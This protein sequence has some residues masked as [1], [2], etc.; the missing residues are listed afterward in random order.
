[1]QMFFDKLQNKIIVNRDSICM[2]DDI[3]NHQKTFIYDK[4]VTVEGFT[5]IVKKY[6]L[7]EINGEWILKSKTGNVIFVYKQVTKEI[8][9][10]VDPKDLIEA[11]HKE[12]ELCFYHRHYK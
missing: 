12:G 3:D 10:N 2:G 9:Y 1:M 4:G 8:E 5:D 6:H 7:P 11:Y